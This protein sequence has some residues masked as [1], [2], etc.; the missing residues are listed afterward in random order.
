MGN[1]KRFYPFLDTERGLA[2]GRKKNLVRKTPF[3]EEGC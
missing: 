3:L 2:F 1:M